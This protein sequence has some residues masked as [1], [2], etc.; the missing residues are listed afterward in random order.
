MRT[1]WCLPAI[2]LLLQEQA[3]AR[4]R[5]PQRRP[6]TER[7]RASFDHGTQQH[8]HA[9]TWPQGSNRPAPSGTNSVH[10]VAAIAKNAPLR[11]LFMFEL[12]VDSRPEAILAQRTVVLRE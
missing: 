10:A 7:A 11:I 6:R 8:A 2:C 9:L 12:Q 5:S 1:H 3:A 4:R